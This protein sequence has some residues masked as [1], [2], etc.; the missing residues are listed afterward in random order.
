MAWAMWASSQNPSIAEDVSL[1]LASWGRAGVDSDSESMDLELILEAIL[2]DGFFWFKHAVDVEL[3]LI[4]LGSTRDGFPFHDDPL[5][6]V[7]M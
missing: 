2:G 1:H 3:V 7:E 5:R 6:D 4:S